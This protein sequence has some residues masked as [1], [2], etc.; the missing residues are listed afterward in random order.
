MKE[1]PLDKL[2]SGGF[3]GLRRKLNEPVL[4]Q[5]VLDKIRDL[6]GLTHL[7]PTAF[8]VSCDEAH[9]HSYRC[10][11][12]EYRLAAIVERL[13]SEVVRYREEHLSQAQELLRTS[14]YKKTD[15]TN[16]P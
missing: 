6:T 4:D 10:L 9:Q 13:V 2:S 7:S 12:F 3:E 14:G 16:E 5:T 11:E 1:I 8:R 15:L